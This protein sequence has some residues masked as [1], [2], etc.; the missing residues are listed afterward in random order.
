MAEL[1]GYRL[2]RIGYLISGLT[3]F[4]LQILSLMG[5]LGGY[6]FAVLYSVIAFF[7]FW[8]SA[9][10]VRTLFAVGDDI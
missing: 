6:E 4:G 9:Q 5:F 10:F 8:G 1:G 2:L 3:V 7:I